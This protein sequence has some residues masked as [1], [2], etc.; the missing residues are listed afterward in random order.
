M[1][2]VSILL[3]SQ[4]TPLL[5]NFFLASKV[6]SQS[7]CNSQPIKTLED[8]T[9]ETQKMDLSEDEDT[10]DEIRSKKSFR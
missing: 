4:V 3:Q 7:S 1:Q 10:D 6:N 2:A 8:E 5:T 9:L